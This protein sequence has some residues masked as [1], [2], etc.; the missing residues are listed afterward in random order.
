MEHPGQISRQQAV[1]GAVIVLAS[2]AAGGFNHW[3]SGK[4]AME[5]AYW[6]HEVV[7]APIGADTLATTNS[8]EPLAQST[9]AAMFTVDEQGQLLVDHATKAALDALWWELSET[10]DPLALEH[11]QT[12]L[13]TA[14]PGAAGM[15]AAALL[16]SYQ[17][18]RL[19]LGSSAPAEAPN[20][21]ISIEH[22]LQR[23]A[24]V[25]QRHF[26]AATAELL[27]G[28]EEAYL[29][30]LAAAMRVEADESLTAPQK[31]AH[32]QELHLRLGDR[33]AEAAAT[34]R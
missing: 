25:R 11:M 6:Q 10:A 26:D 1:I 18:Y 9:L 3:Q 27:F 33:Q 12:R 28:E 29:R 4:S 13:R 16:G 14:L 30:A 24:A 17:A 8:D 5:P 19:E 21:A 32:L 31:P 23:E 15:R 34:G 2:V 7:L 20:D 22:Q